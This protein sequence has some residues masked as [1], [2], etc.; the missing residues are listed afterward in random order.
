MNNDKEEE[1]F[2]KAIDVVLKN[3]GGLSNNKHDKGGVTK[4]GIS[5]KS[6]PCLDIANL[7]IT[8]AIAIY[9][10]D[11]WDPYPYKKIINPNI[12]IKVF[13]L[14]INMG[15]RAA[16]KVLQQALNFL[17]FDL[18][19]DG[20]FGNMTLNAVNQANAQL[21]LSAIKLS[22]SIYYHKIVASNDSQKIF[23]NGWLNR[24]YA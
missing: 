2:Y 7:T 23:L 18:S 17:G 1:I 6:Y 13:D 4:Y 22:A 3:E 21:L 12:A 19:I 10:R 11:F 16:H 20:K 8:Q 9:K 24:A 5:K 15:A 14:A